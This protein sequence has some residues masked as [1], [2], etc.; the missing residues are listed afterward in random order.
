MATERP[1][2]PTLGDGLGDEPRVSTLELFFDL[3]FVFTITQLTALLEHGLSTETVAQVVLVFVVVFWMYGGYAW[4]T[5]A[6]PPDRPIRRL[7][8]ILGMGAFFICA[9]A[10]P[11][12]FDGDGVYFGVGY[13]IVVVV[14]ASLYSRTYRSGVFL[15][16]APLNV[17]AALSVLVAGTLPRPAAY[18][19]WALAIAVQFVAPRIAG[20]TGA[21][22]LR[23][24]HFVERHGLLLLIALGESV[25]A[26]GVGA[27]DRPLD[28]GTLIGALLGLALAA[29]LWWTY[30]GGDE[31][32]AGRAMSGADPLAR[33]GL[34]ING[35]FF[36]FIPML[37]GIV[38]TAAGI[39]GAIAHL[40]D[41]S[42]V[43][44]ALILG[45]GV[46]LYLA[47]ECAF[48]RAMGVGWN[49]RRL[50]AVLAAA[51]TSSLGVAASGG[52][53][54]AALALIPV[55]IAALDARDG[56][57]DLASRLQGQD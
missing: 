21:F 24:A 47:G 39:H 12:I 7:L 9:L 42:G 52:A 38:A 19:L 40:P 55:L 1:L 22:E 2:D 57:I 43:D 10:L 5:N 50:L 31:E 26:V 13:L 45:G 28:G 15:R 27:G 29:G 54:L 53:Q 3:V 16:L 46:A 18:G 34:A 4:L 56:S 8:L 11:R 49:G 48:R 6:V 36:A 35:Y 41:R 20:S 44:D 37:L 23:P 14:H 17:L 32:I 33:F 25:I 51:A 30:F